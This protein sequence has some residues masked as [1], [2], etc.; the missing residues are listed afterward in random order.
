MRRKAAK[1]ELA[2][3]GATLL[4]RLQEDAQPGRADVLEAGEVQHD[5][6]PT[7]D[8]LCQHLVQILG[9]GAGQATLNREVQNFPVRV[10]PYWHRP[11]VSPFVCCRVTLLP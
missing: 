4:G 7:L 9:G 11:S 6:R 10:F 1:R 3:A 8:L 2:T 5:S